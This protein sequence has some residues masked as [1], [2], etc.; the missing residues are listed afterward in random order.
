MELRTTEDYSQALK[1]TGICPAG[2]L[3]CLGPATPLSL[4]ISPFWNDI[5]YPMPAPPLYPGSRKLV[6]WCLSPQMGSN[7]VPGKIIPKVSVVSG[8]D[9][10][11]DEIGNFCADHS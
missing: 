9:H 7:F 1:P 4:T 6:S 11:E 10:S 5:V 3:T 8:L 2:I